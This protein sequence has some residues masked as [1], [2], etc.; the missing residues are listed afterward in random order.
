MTL[1]AANLAVA[2]PDGV[3]VVRDADAADVEREALS[4]RD[5]DV[6]LMAAA[7]A[8]YRPAES[9]ERKACQGRRSLDGRAHAHD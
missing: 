5:A 9:G 7:V 4:R 1:L 3:E 6:V 8:D 2:P